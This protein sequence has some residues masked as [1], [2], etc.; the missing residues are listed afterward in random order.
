MLLR[1]SAVRTQCNQAK[2]IVMLLSGALSGAGSRLR[3]HPCRYTA[4]GREPAHM[5]TI[6]SIRFFDSIDKGYLLLDSSFTFIIA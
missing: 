2:M 3:H 6:H 4:I 5:Y 1:P